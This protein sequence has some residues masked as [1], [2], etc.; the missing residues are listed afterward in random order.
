[1]PIIAH[2]LNNGGQVVLAY[3]HEH[4]VI[5]FDIMADESLPA[6]IIV[7]STL[8]AIAFLFLFRR[9]SDQRKFIY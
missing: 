3:L 9:I 1:V 7:I 2:A 8:A 5:Q 4:G 6:Y